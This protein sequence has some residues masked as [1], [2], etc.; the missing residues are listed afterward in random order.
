MPIFFKD[1]SVLF[2]VLLFALYSLILVVGRFGCIFRYIKTKWNSY[3]KTIR[4]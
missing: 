2:V 1:A 3:G 4:Y